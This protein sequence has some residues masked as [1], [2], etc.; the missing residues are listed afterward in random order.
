[1]QTNNNKIKTLPVVPLRNIVTFPNMVTHFDVG[2]PK[3]LKAIEEAELKDSKILLLAQK[4]TYIDEPEID[5]VYHVGTIAEIKQ[6]LKLP[7]GQMRVL[8]EGETKARVLTFQESDEYLGATVELIESDRSELTV[9]EEAAY[10][11]IK[12][13][14]ERYVSSN[15]NINA[16]AM[17]MLEDVANPSDLI[18]MVASY[19]PI[20]TEDSQN[21]LEIDDRY[22][23][24]I[25]FHNILQREIELQDIEDK[26]SQRV[27]E[28]MSEVQKEYY[29][30]EQI[31]AIREELGE[32]DQ[33]SEMDEY[34]EKI[35]AL[36]MSEEN[37][38]K[39][40]KEA[41]RLEKINPN[42]AEYG[43]IINYLDWIVDL[44]WKQEKEEEIDISYAQKILDED[45]YGLKDVK[46]RIIEFL[47]LRK[48]SDTPKGPILCLVGPP[49]VGKTSIAK[50]VARSLN[51]EF[52][53][54]SLGGV[55]DESEIRG[56]RRTYVGAMPGSI[57]S[58][59][60]NAG[61]TDPVFLL[62]EID[63]LD[64]GFR[65]DPSSAL[66]EVLDPEQN[67][68]FT[69]RFLDMPY[70]LSK[71]LFLTTANNL[72]T[73]P[74]PLRDRMEVITISGYTPYEKLEIAKR[75]ILPKQLKSANIEQDKLTISDNALMTIIE[76]YTR[77]A[78]VR[79]L[80][81]EVQ[82]II[83]K[84]AVQIV[85]DDRERIRITDG[86]IHIYLGPKRFL[87]DEMEKE[88]QIGVANGLAYTS[89][90]GTTLSVEANVTKGKGK[91]S[92]TG[93]LGDVM[94]ESAQTA[95]TYIRSVGAE[96]GIEE[97]FINESDLHLH[98]PEGATPKDGPSAGITI[99]TAMLSALT[100]KKVR[101][102]VAMTGEITLRGRV[103]PIG[104]L[105]E[106][107]MAATRMGI[108]TVIIPKENER[109]LEEVDKA[110]TDPLEIISVSDV[111]EVFDIAIV[112]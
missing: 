52:V 30:R 44:P 31:K 101:R 92:L 85:R 46:E 89:V 82:K 63:K 96:Y 111:T 3:S 20:S 66:L 86:N 47:A 106:K 24:M 33:S 102:D 2:R 107:L 58:N 17:A 56:H 62:D 10:R 57:I 67:N 49:G 29:L 98:V 60:K 72:G 22:E 21:L 68:T 27:K 54:M 91:V 34:I 9:E 15:T 73:I 104:G 45:H 70:D 76:N 37:E 93:K 112:D 87:V 23:R 13:D 50:S 88:D 4:E 75:Y 59:I 109:D 53:R 28:S 43:V 95:L 99:A 35:K 39:A 14:L 110:I 5:E 80:E 38:E 77:E 12:R 69:D 108:T 74:A 26:I 6:V 48:L 78:G 65:G 94:K 42:S 84:A 79:N 90:G 81:R 51:R 1:M 64:S 8:I 16:T 40:L 103:L 11:M 41:Q 97:D 25:E 100:G 83:R 105:K 18:D 7:Q 32:E 55:T 19:L 61:T 71:V 36:G